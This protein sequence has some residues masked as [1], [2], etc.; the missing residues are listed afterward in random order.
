MASKKNAKGWSLPDSHSGNVREA[1]GYLNFSSGN[2]DPLFLR[3]LNAIWSVLPDQP[4]RHELLRQLL[5]E[6][7]TRL[8]TDQPA[9]ADAS[10]ARAVIDLGLND[11]FKAYRSF[12]ADL[13]FHLTDQDFE[14]PFFLAALLEAVLLQGAPWDEPDR[15]VSAALQHLNDYVGYRPIAVLENGRKMEIYPHERLRPIPVF[16]AGAGVANGPYHDLLEHTLAF[17]KEA[18]QDILHEAHFSLEQLEELAIDQRAYDHLHPVNKRTN[19]LFGEWDPHRIDNKGNYRRFIIRKIILDS[20]QDWIDDKDSRVKRSE[21]LFDAAAALCGTMLMASSVS[22]SGPATHDSTISLTSLLPIVARRRDEF[23]AR[24]M[25]SVTGDRR[26]RLLKEEQKTQQPFGHVRQFLNMRLAG[27]GARQVQHRELAHLYAVMG[28]PA[29]SRQQALTIPAASVR[30]ETEVEC[31]V[32]AAHSALDAGDVP[33]AFAGLKQIPDLLRRGIDC[34]AFVDPW[35]ILGFQGQFPLFSSREDAIPDN[36]V[37]TLLSLMEQV[38][39]AFSRCLGEAAARGLPVL[40][41]EISAT[42]HTLA[43]WWDR[44]GSDVI[45]DLPDVSG[46]DSWESASHVSNSLAEWREAGEAAGD[47]SFWRNHVEKFQSAQSYALVVDALLQ[48]RDYVAAMGLLMQWLGQLEDVGFECPQHSIFSLLMRWMK[49]VSAETATDNSSSPLVT[50]R[51]MF[52]FLEANADDWWGVPQLGSLRNASSSTMTDDLEFGR[53]EP[54][55][56]QKTENE[57]D[58]VFGAAYDGVV[59]RDSAEDGNWGDTADSGE[60]NFRNT[61]FETL[62]REMEPRL[63]FLNAVGQ[64]WQ[65]A[66]AR[67]AAEIQRGTNVWSADPRLSEAIVTWHRQ[68]QRWQI[69]L[70]EL[71]ENIWDHEISE[72]MGD[73]DSNVE[74][75][76]QLQVKF[77]LLH[78]VISTLICLRNAERLLNGII[79]EE[80]DVPR[81]TEQDRQLARIYRAV[82]QRDVA[83]VRELMPPFLSRL[84]KN[85]LLYIPLENGGE[86]GQILRTQALQSVVRFLLRELPR[87]GL[88]RET[89]HLLYTAFRMERKWRPKGQAITEFDRLFAIALRSTLQSLVG[90]VQTWS[91]GEVDTEE[92]IDALNRVLDPYQ[93]LW[94]E[95]SRTM[96]ISAVD[97]LR[98]EEDWEEVT[99]FIK[100][101]G[102]DLFHASQLTLGNVRAILHNGVDWFLDYLEEEQDPLRPI[103]LLEDLDK[104][105]IDRED[106]EWF[107]DQVYSIIV[108]RFDRFL[109]YNTTTTQ[110]DYGEMIYSLLDFL[111]LE[112]LYDRDAWNLTPQVI[113]H[114]VLVRNG[115]MLAAEVREAAFEIQT[116]ELADGHLA[117]LSKLQSQYGMRMPTITDHLKERFVKPLAVNRMLALVARAVADARAGRQDDSPIFQQLSEEI[118]VYLEDSWGSGVDIPDW[119]RSLERE[120]MSATFSE[121]GGRPGME[122]DLEVSPLPMTRE[123]F[124]QQARLWKENLTPRNRPTRKSGPRRKGESSE[125]DDL[126]VD[127]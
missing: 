50:I 91:T 108:D 74:Y 7:L 93:W 87:M 37:E 42:H 100:R 89:W 97:G 117:N 99:R 125:D 14:Q 68:A 1:L 48:K 34:G 28:Y 66:A 76:I 109:E 26:Q 8:S 41:E 115:M 11:L 25:Q 30:L 113:V 22:G 61:E 85:P 70:A 121:D 36:R 118:D 95:H 6:T 13:L 47:I 15:I 38:F 69:D 107:L 9:F 98:K 82:I 17:L 20:L 53:Q 78:Q 49:L 111:R 79:P 12:H 119:L 33:K 94:H 102:G 18:P 4:H 105:L 52:D 39:N 29:A 32:S 55:S 81:G 27:Y 101:Y 64:L 112:A 5:Q 90:S 127:D 88:L 126:A 51:R 31:T 19:Y 75:D 65:L 122:A 59:F 73:H 23:Y 123:E 40:R 21:R 71:M 83:T 116:L 60:S 54:E 96:R 2:S 58:D 44:Y 46:Q 43:E 24:V 35:N 57:E 77:Y 114:E 56:F 86:P 72:P 110:S 104:G 92:L 16:V 80:V 106:A 45:E 84:A 124:L 120:V 63:K 67:F 3:N 62:N 103:K 10:Q